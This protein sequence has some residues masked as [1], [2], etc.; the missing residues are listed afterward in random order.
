[1]NITSGGT[2]AINI[3]TDAN[4][5]AITIG[6]GTGATA[7]NFISGTGNINFA[8]DGS[9]TSGII[10]MGNSNTSTPDLLTLDKGAADP[11]GATA[12]MFYSTNLNQFRGYQ[13]GA[14]KN[15]VMS[16]T[17]TK[18]I[19]LPAGQAV[20]DSISGTNSNA[21][22]WKLYDSADKEQYAQVYGN[23]ATQSLDV[24]YETSV[25]SDFVSWASNAIVITYKTSSA[26]A[27]SSS[28]SCTV[29]GTD[30]AV[31]ATTTASASTG[32]AVISIPSSSLVGDTWTLGSSFM[33]TCN[34][35]VNN[36]TW[37]DIGHVLLQY[38]Y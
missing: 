32:V 3:G 36:A 33:I 12:G 6:N 31:A 19:F 21:D 38:N 10:S 35:A 1:L 15:F 27:A 30:G 34:A 9:S 20:V 26:T 24:T 23:T 5:K 11:T 29:R 22:S 18:S 25:P 14:W 7:L 13:N 4:A 28:A 17:S 37:V 8:V 16:A 2:G